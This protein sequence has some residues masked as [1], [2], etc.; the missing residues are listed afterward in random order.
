MWISNI[1][2]SFFCSQLIKKVTFSGLKTRPQFRAATKWYLFTLLVHVSFCV[3][4]DLR[5]KLMWKT[6]YSG[7]DLIC[8]F[9]ITILNH[10]PKLFSI[11]N[12]YFCLFGEFA[13]VFKRKVWY[14]QV[15][16]LYIGARVLSSSSWHFKLDTVLLLSNLSSSWRNYLSRIPTDFNFLS[17][18]SK[19]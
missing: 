17:Y 18:W 5:I 2:R 16:H 4:S 12:Y 3:F 8:E 10:N 13:K 6:L 14:V 19:A 11:V 1:F 15:T 9:L 7:I